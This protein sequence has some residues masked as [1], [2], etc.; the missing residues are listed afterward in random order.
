M[1]AIVYNLFRL[2]MLNRFFI[3]FD[4]LSNVLFEFD[5]LPGKR[6]RRVKR[7]GQKALKFK[8]HLNYIDYLV[9]L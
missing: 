5:E 1:P 6:E 7:A 4:I 8:S 3:L 9:V 2:S